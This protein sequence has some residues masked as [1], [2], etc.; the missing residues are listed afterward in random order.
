MS[1]VVKEFV[2]KYHPFAKQTELK[3]GINARF[4]LAQAALESAWGRTAPGNM[5]FGVKDSD[6]LNGNEQLLT[7]TEYLTNP[8]KK[9]PVVLSVQAVIIKGKRM[10]KY[11]VKDWF[12]KYPSPEAS[13][14]DHANFFYKWP[15]YKFALIFRK[16]PYRF[17]EE[18]SKAGYATDPNYG[19]V[20]KKVISMID[21]KIE[22]NEAV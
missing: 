11:K 16:D 18:I 17:A 4:I 1:N 14:T 21:A 22:I 19:Q 5:F 6:G 2:N 3:S 9:F 8:D 7:T 15:R 20:L 12:R 13:F 10:F